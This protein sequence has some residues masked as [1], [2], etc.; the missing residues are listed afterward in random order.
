MTDDAQCLLIPPGEDFARLFCGRLI[1][2]HRDRL[3]DLSAVTVVL[4]HQTLAQALRRQL[5]AAAGGSLLMP[6]LLPLQVLAAPE[7]PPAS[8][9]ACQ[10]RLAEAVSRFRFLFPGQTPLRVAEA[11]FQL[12]EELEREAVTLP[13]DE[14]GLEALLRR[15]YGADGP[16]AAL[17]REAEIVHKLHQAFREELGANAPAVAR[18]QALHNALANWPAE[19]PLWFAGF[20]TL[21]ASE[22]QCIAAALQRL[23][24]ARVVLQGRLAGRDGAATRRLLQAL[25]LPE[26]VT[27]TE[28][29]GRGQGLDAGFADHAAACT[30]A[31]ALPRVDWGD[32]ALVAADDAEHE[33]QCADLAVREALLAG[34]QRV[35][36]IS[37][38]RRFARRLRAR[39]ERAGIAL[40][41]RGGWALS[42]SRAAAT[43]DAWLACVVEDFPYRPLLALLK[44]G[45]LDGG[46]AWAEALEP[47]AIRRAV[48]G[49]AAQ[50]QA[51]LSADE[52]ARWQNLEYAASAFGSLQGNRPGAEYAEA[53]LHSLSRLGLTDALAN[54]AA[55]A[56][57]LAS[58]HELRS[59]LA[60]TTLQLHW[61][62]FRA[63]LDRVL[64]DA[65]FPAAAGDGRVQLLTLDQ[66]QGLSA[67]A[68]VLA[69]AT[70]ALFAPGSAP[71]FNRAVR[72]ELGLPTH[73]VQQALT[74]ARLRRVMQA[75][76]MVR[77]LY[78]PAGPGELG[79]PAPALAALMAFA[80]A[81]GCAIPQDTALAR[82][83][84]LAE[85]A[86]ESPL[87]A[88]QQRPAP[89]GSGAHLARPL[90]ASGHQAL[91]DCPYA[92]HARQRLRL[93]ADEAPDDPP[94]ASDYGERVHRILSA[95][96]QAEPG[97][98]APY[99]GP[100]GSA[101]A[102]AMARHLREIG[103]AVFREDIAQQPL[104]RFWQ[105]AFAE[106]LP[107]LVQ[108]LNTLP[109][110]AV[111]VE[112]DLDA[113][114][115]GW[116]L[117]GRA[118]RIEDDGE[119]RRLIDLKTGS[120]PPLADL[121][122]GEAVQLPHYALL[123][124]GITRAEY[125]AVKTERTPGLD[126]EQLDALLPDLAQ[127][128]GV[129][130]AA[131]RRG[132]PLPAHGDADSCARCDFIGV[133]RRQ[134]WARA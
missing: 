52:R 51:L 77:L 8:A 62:A 1:A 96:E 85:V 88:P 79:E 44:S 97:L 113:E 21:S 90:S 31:A 80:D 70:A 98:P 66:T 29:T 134:D 64:E 103:E 54:D 73:R 47:R 131:L 128:L 38:D 118:D 9:L 27:T 104:A 7:V 106:S 86:A 22:A 4:P 127:R 15:G 133:C 25:G 58:L 23:P 59:A 78:A 117:R 50:W 108:R 100:R 5:P 26:P 94:D 83:A 3:P 109:T 76:P 75:A 14:P 56:R 99:T 65:S 61:S 101:H 53:M 71:F 115:D 46:R 49:G 123:T 92:F 12:F 28:T 39:L 68:V 116:S 35:A 11:L 30:R 93:R 24:T 34:A 120:T 18:R 13:G 119:Q 6:R 69:G 55:G 114:R 41:D 102:E 81:A 32:L 60:A 95:F 124:G 129:M 16:L 105:Q 84:R 57:L 122:A 112:R 48:A 107:W 43:L 67:D 74:L 82:R 72:L 87:P 19:A 20:D 36:V 10:L 110:A 2:H 89:P 125:W 91:I 42:T 40:A 37:N 63:L 132:E 45:F 126:G 111:Q 121:I 130:A 33:A 17:S